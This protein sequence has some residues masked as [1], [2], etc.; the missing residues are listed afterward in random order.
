MV[1]WVKRLTAVAQVTVEV[2]I[3]SLAWCSGLRILAW[4]LLYASSAAIKKNQTNSYVGDLIIQKKIQNETESLSM[5]K[6]I[7]LHLTNYSNGLISQSISFFS[8]LFFFVFLS[9]LGPHPQHMEV[10]RLGV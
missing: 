10:P 7:I 1:Q 6:I 8:F 3:Q 9:F 4:E 5:S 2:L